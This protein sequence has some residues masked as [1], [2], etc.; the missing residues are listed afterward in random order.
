M[1]VRFL[2]FLVF[3]LCFLGAVKSQITVDLQGSSI[4]ADPF[5]IGVNQVT[6]LHVVILNNGPNA[7]PTGAAQVTVSMNTSIIQWVTPIVPTGG[8]GVFTLVDP[9]SPT[10]TTG[11]LIFKNTGG[12]MPVRADCEI[13]L[14][15]RGAAIGTSFLNLASSISPLSTNVSDIN[16]N[17]QSATGQIYVVANP[18][19][20][21]PVIGTQPQ[22]QSICV[23]NSAT[24][25]V[26]ATGDGTLSYQWQKDGV[27][28][29]NATSS[30]YT[31]SSATTGSAG[32]YSVVVSSTNGTSTTSG[33]AQLTINTGPT[34]TTQPFSLNMCSGNSAVFSVAASN[35]TSY[36]WRKNGSNITGAVGAIYVINPVNATDAA[37]YDVVVNGACGSTTSNPA[38]LIISSQPII[39]TQPASLTVCVNQSVAFSVTASGGSNTYQWR[40][41]G[42]AIAGATSSTYILGPAALND[43]GSYDVVVTGSCTTP[44]IS[45]VAM[46]TVNSAPSITTQPVS[47]SV[48]TSSSA[49]FSVAATGTNLTFQWRKNGVNIAGAVNQSYSIPSVQSTDAASYDVVVSGGSGLCATSF[50]SNAATLTLKAAPIA[51]ASPVNICSGSAFS[52]TP[53]SSISGTQYAWTYSLSSGASITGASSQSVLTSPPLS[54]TLTNTA[55]TSGT[56]TYTVTPSANGCDGS[57]FTFAVTVSGKGSPVISNCPSNITVAQ[58]NNCRT[59]VSWTEPTATNVNNGCVTGGA[60]TWTKSHVPGS[61]FPLGATTVTYVASNGVAADTCRFTVT[62]NGTSPLYDLTVSQ[63]IDNLQLNIGDSLTELIAIR[64]IGTGSTQGVFNFTVTNYTAATGLQMVLINTPTVNL[65]G[66]T[67]NLNTADFDYNFNSVIHSFASKAGVIMGPAT[68]KLIAFKLKRVAGGVG[69]VTNTITVTDGC[70]ERL[71][72]NTIANTIT[73]L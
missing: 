33:T 18:P 67:Y 39:T 5:T 8:C 2:V 71:N 31:V 24:F 34:I 13:M 20:A 40:K 36:Q 11:T 1:K 63:V 15:I 55:S 58:L 23:G 70:E 42:V 52:I 35:A 27:N 16:G 22:A 72:N 46:L 51:S 26:S 14:Q 62:V 41:N 53:T 21:A 56:I 69:S 68:I 38:T 19:A 73:K 12:S 47:T 45:S 3:F 64:N 28:I 30:S 48:C 50:T 37:T 4:D 32:G 61:T 7:I 49:S 29:P 54:Q 17:N 66:S 57:T 25:S 59:P 44:T 6:T 65:F 10:A 60:I 9:P 43:V